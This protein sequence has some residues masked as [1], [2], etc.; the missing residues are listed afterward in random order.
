M[1]RTDNSSISVDFKVI[2]I[3][4]KYCNIFLKL[5]VLYLARLVNRRQGNKNSSKTQDV[6]HI[7]FGSKILGPPP[8]SSRRVSTRV[9]AEVR[10]LT[11]Q[12][13]LFY[14]R[15]DWPVRRRR[16]T[17]KTYFRIDVRL[18][19]M[20]VCVSIFFSDDGVFQGNEDCRYQ[21]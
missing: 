15:R 12:L 8:S 18:H 6:S 9:S 11:L 20:Y 5:I 16:L 4:S 17:P 10:R 13:F 19:H 1:S 3:Y 14:Q 21:K 7:A 2:N